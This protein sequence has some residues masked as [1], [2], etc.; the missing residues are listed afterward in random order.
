MAIDSALTLM[1]EYTVLIR[2][3][4]SALT[5]EDFKNGKEKAIGFLVGQTMKE[6][7]GKADPGMI[8]QILTEILEQ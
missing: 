3:A 8:N 2:I 4:V 1:H 6:M 7:K 5:V